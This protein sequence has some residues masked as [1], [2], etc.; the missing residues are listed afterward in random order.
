MDWAAGSP[1]NT[2]GNRWIAGR[3]YIW[4]SDSDI[5]RLQKD[6]RQPLQ[7][8]RLRIC[9]TVDVGDDFARGGGKSDIPSC[10]QASVFRT[11]YANPKAAGDR[12]RAVRGAIVDDNYFV[13]RV[14][15]N[16]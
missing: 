9:I 6:H 15:H 8:F 5:V 10:T 2:L 1:G 7:P 11:D 16:F 14:I 13:V 4:S 12:S 3:S